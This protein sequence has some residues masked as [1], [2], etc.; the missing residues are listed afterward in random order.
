MTGK[1]TSFLHLC[2]VLATEILAVKNMSKK[3]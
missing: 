1:R 3:F 2:F